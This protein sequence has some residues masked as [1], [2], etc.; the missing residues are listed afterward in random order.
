MKHLS[1]IWI[2]VICSS[3]QLHAKRGLTI[4]DKAYENIILILALLVILAVMI[5]F[6]NMVFN[7]LDLQKLRLQQEMGI[8]KEEVVKTMAMPSW[9]KIYQWMWSL[10]PKDKES[11]ID[12]GH[13]YDGIRELDNKLPPWWLFLF[14]GTIAFSVVY[15]W[16]YEWGPND[17]SSEM[18]YRIAMEEAEEQKERFFSKMTASIDENN[19]IFIE[20]EK[21]LILGQEVFIK[22]C[23]ACHGPEGQG[24]V[25]PNLTDDYWIHGGNIKDIFKII[26]YG[27]PEKGMIPWNTQLKPTTIQS[28]AS[29]IQTLHGTNPPNPKAK[30]GTLYV[31][32][33]E[34]AVPIG[35]NDAEVDDLNLTN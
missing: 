20:D 34:I 22:N 13:S 7:F 24:L 35:S 8:E 4:L 23:A 31:P 26:K 11:T 21:S 28:V 30:E 10:V 18:E 6:F 32:E 14:Y 3:V 12:L 9:K 25:G 1:K 15:M 16:I 33:E 27:V 5:T 17:W 19:V 29:Y 2:L